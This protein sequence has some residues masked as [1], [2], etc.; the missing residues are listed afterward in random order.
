MS[1]LERG[2]VVSATTYQDSLG[3]VEGQSDDLR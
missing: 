3:G 2:M 1:R